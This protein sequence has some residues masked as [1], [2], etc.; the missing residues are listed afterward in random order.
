MNARIL[1][2]LLLAALV[3]E[4]RSL[5]ALTGQRLAAL[6]HGTIRSPIPGREST[7][8]LRK[9]REWAADIGEIKISDDQNSIIS[10]QVTGVDIEPII[11]AAKLQ[12]SPGNR[13]RLIREM[14]FS[15][16]GIDDKP[17]L[18]ARYSF[19]WR[20]TR[21]EAS[22][23][24]DNVREI[25]DERLRTSGEEPIGEGPWQSVGQRQRSPHVSVQS[26]VRAGVPMLQLKESGSSRRSG[27]STSVAMRSQASSRRWTSIP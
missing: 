12:D 4:V 3:P 21:R 10:I 19:N 2:T 26:R 23:L 5:R 13:K 27:L 25:S 1:K 14:L 6:N 18:F 7:D 22:I 8:V 11:A 15:A 16:L 24:Y 20:G 9:C 17:D